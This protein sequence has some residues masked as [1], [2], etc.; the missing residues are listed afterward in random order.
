[1]KT[2]GSL[3][4]LAPAAHAGEKAVEGNSGPVEAHTSPSPLDAVACPFSPFLP[5]RAPL[6]AIVAVVASALTPCVRASPAFAAACGN[7]PLF[8]AA[9]DVLPATS[10]GTPAPA[11]TAASV[12]VAS[13]DPG[14]GRVRGPAGPGATAGVVRWAGAT[15]AAEAQKSAAAALAA[16][17]DSVTSTTSTSSLMGAWLV[18]PSK[19]VLSTLSSLGT[20][21]GLASARCAE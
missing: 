2:F 18:W 1:V 5:S 20:H 7:I 12:A 14:A 6:W 17:P 8:L 10:A 3:E 13:E 19:A 21:V 15:E 4:E 11:L 16:P 9:T